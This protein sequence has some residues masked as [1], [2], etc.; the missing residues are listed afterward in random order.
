MQVS[1]G[2]ASASLRHGQHGGLDVDLELEGGSV[3]QSP[4]EP[5]DIMARA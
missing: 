1:A 4:V 2:V 3:P 5:L